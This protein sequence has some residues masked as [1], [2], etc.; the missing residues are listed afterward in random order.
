M[1]K[2]SKPA[3]TFQEQVDLLKSRGLQITDDR[4]AIRHLSNISYY[5]LSAYMLPF[6]NVDA[7]GKVTDCF[8]EGTRWEDIYNLYRF[9][10]KLRLLLFDAIERIEIALRTQIIYQLSHKY[11]SHW[12]DDAKLFG[13]KSH[14]GQ[15]VFDCIQ[16]HINEQL[17]PA[18]RRNIE[19]IHH[20]FKKYD[21]PPTPPSWMSIELLYI[22]DLSKICE[23]LD[24]VRDRVDLAKAFGVP[25]EDIFCSWL[26]SISYA[27]NIC[28]HHARLW[29]IKLAV[30]PRK[31]KYSKPDKVWFTDAEMD[32][33]QSSKLYYLLC[34]LLY[35]LQT[36]N[37]NS[38]FK[39][40]FFDLLKDFPAV[41]VGYMGFP[42]GW[43]D[44]PL[45]QD[46]KPNKK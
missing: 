10:R 32:V 24:M 9:D 2:Y 37:P 31:F 40:H 21:D 12:Q 43:K 45:W 38:K 34:V 17:K 5:R 3:L 33:V 4:R 1:N 29:N 8:K 39:A 36:V 42:E 16:K 28:A 6:K 11:G 13:T 44:H 41:D 20:Y 14:K 19:F 26:H 15:T 35:L 23:G 30:Q 27:R 25:S 22:S 46:S 18:N 7:D